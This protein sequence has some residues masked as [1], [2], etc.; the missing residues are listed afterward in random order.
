MAR[1][2][3]HRSAETDASSS[4]SPAHPALEL[5][6]RASDPELYS[7]EPG[8]DPMLAEIV[9]HAFAATHASGAALAMEDNGAVKC[10]AR[11]GFMAPSLGAELDREAGISGLC[12]RTGEPVRCDDAATDGR[13][14]GVAARA[15]GICS[16]LAVPLKSQGRSVGLLEVF[17]ELPYAFATEQEA[18]LQIAA[19]RILL[20]Q[21]LGMNG[22]ASVQEFL[23]EIDRQPAPLEVGRNPLP[24]ADIADAPAVPQ[25]AAA[26]ESAVLPSHEGTIGMGEECAADKKPTHRLLAWVIGLAMVAG[27][28][29]GLSLAFGTGQPKPAASAPPTMTTQAQ[30]LQRAAAS[31]ESSAQY[32]L[33]MRFRSGEGVERNDTEAVRW[34]RE[35][36]RQGNGDAQ[37]ELGNAY[38]DGRGIERDP[39]NAYACYVLAGAN[40]NSASEQALKFLTPKLSGPQIGEVRD[41]VGQ[42]YLE[43]RGT[44]VNLVAAYTWFSLADVAG[45]ADGQR[46]KQVLASKMS[47][48]Q[49]T[50]A[51]RR[52]SDW[53]RRHGQKPR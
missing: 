16:I 39:I 18:L 2:G 51:E 4:V 12:L 47:R 10:C 31:G 24:S 14:D 29:I 25:P 17:S 13:V 36:A 44:P 30:W 1:T 23:A 42:M 53:L 7:P 52:A 22:L 9:E 3:T 50:A 46:Q 45:N 11:A 38:A 5:V 19:E 21:E 15:L 28:A 26:N 32:E 40:G 20:R 33:A 48:A 6:P 49:V 35:S 27:A 8:Q 37:Y 43:G 34:L 41:T